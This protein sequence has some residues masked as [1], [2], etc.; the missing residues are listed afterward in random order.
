V[1][2]PVTVSKGTVFPVF[3]KNCALVLEEG[4]ESTIGRMLSQTNVSAP[5]FILGIGLTKMVALSANDEHPFSE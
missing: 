3:H 1:P 5:R 4:D 2:S